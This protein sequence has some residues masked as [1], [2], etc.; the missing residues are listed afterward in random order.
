MLLSLCLWFNLYSTPMIMLFPDLNNQWIDL[1][2][3]NEAIWICEIL[4]KFIFNAQGE[5]D[6]Y[7]AFMRYVRSTMV[8]DLVA[9]LP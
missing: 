5:E 3:F 9:T 6:P 8:I 7:D 1:L 2:W 4:R